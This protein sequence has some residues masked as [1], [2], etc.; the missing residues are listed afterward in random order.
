MK[1]FKST[2]LFLLLTIISYFV[3]VPLALKYGNNKV[4]D[5]SENLPQLL[6]YLSFIAAIVSL[7]YAIFD[8]NIST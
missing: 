6:A 3:G 7:L 1:K 4:I 8:G 2:I 5:H